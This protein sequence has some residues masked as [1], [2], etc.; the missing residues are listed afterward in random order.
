MSDYSEIERQIAQGLIA[1]QSDGELCKVCG[2][3]WDCEH[4]NNL[5][6]YGGPVT[7][8]QMY[9]DLYNGSVRVTG[10]KT[11]RLSTAEDFIGRTVKINRGSNPDFIIVDEMANWPANVT[12]KII[13]EL[14]GEIT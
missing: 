13:D 7:K 8:A 5:L 1:E 10:T 14:T 2:A 4:K 3:Y 9:Q 12:Q 11:G 6:R